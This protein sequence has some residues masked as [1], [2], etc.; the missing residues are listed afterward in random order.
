M[1]NMCHS[2]PRLSEQVTDRRQGEEAQVAAVQDAACAVVPA[3]ACQPPQHIEVLHVRYTRDDAT[4]LGE[5]SR[6]LAQ[7]AP[8]IDEVFEDVREDYGVE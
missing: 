7:R 8:G 2:Q 3:A 5:Q 1:A 6:R 4:A